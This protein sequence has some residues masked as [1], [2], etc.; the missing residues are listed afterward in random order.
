MVALGTD[1]AEGARVDVGGAV[2]LPCWEQSKLREAYTRL[3]RCGRRSRSAPEGGSKIAHPLAE[4]T[5]ATED[6]GT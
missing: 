4:F 5:N 2:D 3:A 6:G 1:L